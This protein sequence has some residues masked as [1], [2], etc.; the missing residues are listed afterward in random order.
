MTRACTRQF[1]HQSQLH[2][3]RCVNRDVK[4]KNNWRFCLPCWRFGC[5]STQCH[6]ELTQIL[7]FLL[8]PRLIHHRV[9]GPMR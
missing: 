5:S 6:V 3:V 9:V 1:H 8:L 7:V 4:W 2:P